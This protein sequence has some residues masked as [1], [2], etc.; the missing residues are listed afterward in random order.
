MIEV[1]NAKELEQA[2]KKAV[3][4]ELIWWDERFT[5]TKTTNPCFEEF[6]KENVK[7]AEWRKY[8]NWGN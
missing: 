7:Q 4:G 2:V 1:H 5:K 8:P 3:K 6:L